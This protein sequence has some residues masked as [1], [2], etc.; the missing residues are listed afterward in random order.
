MFKKKES[1]LKKFKA[2]KITKAQAEKI[3]GGADLKEFAEKCISALN[4]C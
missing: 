3:Q 2:A 4:E 1:S